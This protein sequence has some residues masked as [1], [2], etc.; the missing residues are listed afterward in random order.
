M[1]KI[2]F[3]LLT[4]LFLLSINT[5]FA[6][7][8][9][10]EECYSLSAN[11]QRPYSDVTGRLNIISVSYA[12]ENEGKA[13]FEID[14]QTTGELRP[15]D[16]YVINEDKHLKIKEITGNTVEFCLFTYVP[17]QD[18]MD[19]IYEDEQKTYRIGNDK[20]TIKAK[21]SDNKVKFMINSEHTNEMQTE[22]SYYSFGEGIPKTKIM[23]KEAGKENN[24]HYARY[25]LDSSK[26]IMVEQQKP[27]ITYEE[28]T[29]TGIDLSY[30]PKMFISNGKLNAELVVGDQAP[31]DDV[32]AAIDIVT[33]FGPLK[34]VKPTKLASEIYEYEK[35]IISI[36]R[37]C[38]NAVT[39]QILRANAQDYGND[40]SIGLK[41]GQA[42]VRLFEYNGYKHMLLMGFSRLE[43][44]QAARAISMTKMNGNK[45]I[46]NF[47]S[48][49]M[50]TKEDFTTTTEIVPEET[51]QEQSPPV[52]T[53]KPECNGCE[54]NGAC[55]LTGIRIIEKD[56]TPFYC[57]ID[58]DLKKQKENGN[59]CQN[60][61]ECLS[62]DCH[63]GV[64][65]SI[66]EKIEV[67]EKE[68][69]EQRSILDRL[70]NFFKKLFNF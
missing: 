3:I 6:E 53:K 4:L 62:N 24:K 26:I 69:K 29:A 20:Y 36:G 34:Q 41:S 14:G 52:I 38:D 56:S 5:A 10:A 8:I 42:M 40:C 48:G 44:R 31:A 50:P 35:N 61:Y 45:Y 33:F 1:K 60:N 64:C 25:C 23:L 59:A 65:Q 16:V 11:E 17:C 19:K 63:D 43:T 47:K 66:S 37:P 21:F 39:A 55:L 68:L 54:K 67:I 27:Q 30:Y 18:V 51:K 49:V 15:G 28:K 13:K 2:T 32:V 57:D 22:G 58:S 46:F 7:T 12:S 70:V 9:N